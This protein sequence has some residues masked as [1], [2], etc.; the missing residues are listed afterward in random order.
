M[1]WNPQQYLLFAGHRLRPALDLLGR[2]GAESPGTVVDLGCGAGNVT[3]LLRERWPAARIVGYDSSPEM[4]ERAAVDSSIEWRLAD[5]DGWTPEA[6][7][8]VV[9]SNAAL[10]WLGDHPRLFGRLADAVAPGGW[11]AVQMP[12]NWRAPSHS[13]AAAAVRAGP[14]RDRLSGL[15]VTDPLL[16]LEGYHDLLAPRATHLDMWET[17]YFQ[18]LEGENPVVE[19]TKGTVLA[20]L[21]AAL[22]PAERAAF[23]A[24]Y[25]RRVR[26]AYPPR[27]DGR[28]LFPFR[29]LFIV[30]RF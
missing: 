16:P 24:D 12:N 2:I 21:L 27:P 26:Q 22:D 11:L 4:L 19:W 30:A 28:T 13:S 8:D 25:G 10:H 3:R 18:V 6:P 7:V 17:E 9:F 23:E 15:L 20:P 5:L 14:W 1:T 29:R